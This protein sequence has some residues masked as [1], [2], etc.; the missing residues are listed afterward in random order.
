MILMKAKRILAAVLALLMLV[1][2][3]GCK[4]SK[5]KKRGNLVSGKVS[6][7]Y[8]D[9]E[10]KTDIY[11][12]NSNAELPSA[13]QQPGVFAANAPA[14][15][16]SGKGA[17]TSS[18]NK[19]SANPHYYLGLY[20]S[21]WQH[22]VVVKDATYDSSNKYI[23]GKSVKFDSNENIIGEEYYPYGTY[24]AEY[25]YNS[26]GTIGSAQTMY[27]SPANYSYKYD[28]QK[29]L[30]KVTEKSGNIITT[31]TEFTYDN[32]GRLVFV[33]ERLNDGNLDTE[34]KYDSKGNLTECI[35]G[36]SRYVYKYD[37]SNR[38]ILKQCYD[39]ENGGKLTTETERKYDKNGYVIYYRDMYYSDEGQVTTEEFITND[40]NGNP[41]Q[42]KCY[43]TKNGKKALDYTSKTVYSYKEKV[44][45]A[46]RFT[47][48]K[49]EE[50][51]KALQVTEYEYH[52]KEAFNVS[53]D[54]IM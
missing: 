32:N 24:R 16:A 54:T 17:N 40:I 49:N 14:G 48:A 47:Y 25:K 1:S 33:R 50:G 42:V 35:S 36:G 23:T 28:S 21:E 20:R 8:S 7:R 44:T 6:Q 19:A 52:R 26:D 5:S 45:A 11:E 30:A 39:T 18:G 38:L 12:I 22:W 27:C 53:P 15:G 9:G 2:F 31:V 3:A 29:R 4:K 10:G 34:Y 41:D 46:T 37:S 43:S 51:N 13:A